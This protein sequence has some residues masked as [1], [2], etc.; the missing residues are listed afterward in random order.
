MFPT[1]RCFL[2]RKCE[3]SLQKKP[4]AEDEAW[5][6]ADI[7]IA[8]L[9]KSETMLRCTLPGVGHQSF[10]GTLRRHQRIQVLF[11]F[12]CSDLR[13]RVTMS[14]VHRSDHN[15]A[16]TEKTEDFL[17]SY[18]RWCPFNSARNL[19]FCVLK[20]AS[21]QAVCE[22]AL[23]SGIRPLIPLIIAVLPFNFS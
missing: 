2:Q 17:G 15:S 22:L 12:S 7:I 1:A 20:F 11:K 16:L 13:P 19:G 3:A 10:W 5:V 23:V 9:M 6:E 8:N 21:C 14:G 4:V 18:Y